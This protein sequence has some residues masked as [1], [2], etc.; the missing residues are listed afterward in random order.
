MTCMMSLLRLFFQ[1]QIMFWQV[2]RLSSVKGHHAYV[3][4]VM[5][6]HRTTTLGIEEEVR[7]N[8]NIGM[9]GCP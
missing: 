4:K 1:I 7:K 9:S 5:P 6:A 3:D 8:I 2:T